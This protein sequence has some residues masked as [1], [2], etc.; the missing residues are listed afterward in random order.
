MQLDHLPNPA[1][2]VPETTNRFHDCHF[3]GRVDLSHPSAPVFYYAGSYMAAHFQGASLQVV[4][5][6]EGAW[7]EYG[8]QVGFIIDDGEL[9]IRQLAKGKDHQLVEVAVGL[10]GGEHKLTLVKLQGPGNGRGSVTLHDLL[11]D[12]G[13]KLLRPPTLP[14][15]KLEVYGDSV[16]E[17]EG[18]ACPDGTN[19]CGSLAGNSGWL[20]YTNTLARHLGCQVHNLGIGGLAVR[21]HTGWYEDG[22]TGLETTY[23]K[24]NPW[25]V[26][27]AQWDF[28]CY[29]PDLVIMAL[30]VNDQSKFGFDDL[31]LWKETYKRI[32]RD[33]HA[34][35][36]GGNLPFLFA[37]PPINVHEAYQNVAQVAADLK[38]EGVNTRFYRYS[39]EVN[40]HPNRL[41]SARMAQELY[42]YLTSNRLL[43]P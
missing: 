28:N 7:N 9:V 33:I 26:H 25:G 2:F 4:L 18:A 24:L 11:L 30:G 36:G 21:D 35:H 19:D 14:R 5:S 22:K 27:K 38:A 1:G 37:V 40:G 12:P 15:L 16:T 42:E 8:N 10:P 3:V 20:S 41:Q 13:M 34:R 17:G 29:L 43:N 6:D 31:P 39:F 23:D 32:V